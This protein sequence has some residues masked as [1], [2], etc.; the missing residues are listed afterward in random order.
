ME[1]SSAGKERERLESESE[2]P[3]SEHYRISPDDQGDDNEYI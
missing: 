1:S 3:E 2:R